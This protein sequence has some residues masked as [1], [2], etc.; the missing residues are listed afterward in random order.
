M[1]MSRRMQRQVEFK[2]RY[3]QSQE[4]PQV[5]SPRVG[6]ERDAQAEKTPT[7]SGAGPR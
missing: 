2:I 1:K 6:G 3:S 4:L 5:G 7:E